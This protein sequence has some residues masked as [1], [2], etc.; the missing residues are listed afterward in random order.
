MSRSS[1]IPALTLI[2][3]ASTGVGFAAEEGEKGAKAAKHHQQVLAK[4]DANGDGKLQRPE[5]EALREA[6]FPKL[7]TNGDG[8]LSR[9]EFVH[10]HHGKD[11]RKAGT[12]EKGKRDNG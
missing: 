1:L 4:F 5:R 12:K 8:S 11:G 6:R 3:A 7:D 9:D 10:R 2:L